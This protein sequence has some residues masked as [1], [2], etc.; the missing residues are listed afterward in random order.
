M[1]NIEELEKELV[2]ITNKIHILSEHDKKNGTSIFSRMINEML[3]R[4]KNIEV[5]IN[6]YKQRGDKDDR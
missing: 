5:N 3:K 6:Q 4:K 1:R 2:E